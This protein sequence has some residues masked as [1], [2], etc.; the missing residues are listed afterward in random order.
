MLTL[1]LSCN[2]GSF[3]LYGLADLGN[4]SNFLNISLFG[5]L[6]SNFISIFASIDVVFASRHRL[7]QWAFLT[8]NV[9]VPVGLPARLGLA[10]VP[11]YRINNSESLFCGSVV[12]WPLEACCQHSCQPSCRLS[13]LPTRL[14]VF[15]FYILS[16]FWSARL[17]WFRGISWKQLFLHFTGKYGQVERCFYKMYES[18]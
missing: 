14:L 4:F 1:F 2:T 18:L 3:F 8:R 7:L 11:S 5:C 17:T 12:E 10:I 15:L 13:F 9:S 6:I 16:V